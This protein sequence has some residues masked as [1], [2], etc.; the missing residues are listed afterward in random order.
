[1]A[2]SNLVQRNNKLEVSGI[3]SRSS[4]GVCSPPLGAR[5]DG[6]LEESEFKQIPRV[7]SIR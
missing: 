3:L 4:T 6:C 1:M 5:M 7:I 2:Q